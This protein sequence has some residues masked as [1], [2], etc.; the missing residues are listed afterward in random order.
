M[1]DAES[2]IGN[3]TNPSE[4][5]AGGSSDASTPPAAP[6]RSFLRELPV[7]VIIAFVLAVLIKTF[8]AQAFFIPSESMVPTLEVGD[9]ILVNKLAFRLREPQRG[10]IIVFAEQY[11]AAPRS[12][13]SRV[14]SVL[15]EG[16]GVTRPAETDF[17][18]R[19]IG[20]PGETVRLSKGVVTITDT[21]G[22]EITLDESYVTGEPDLEPFGPYTV[23]PG[24]YFVM[25]D[26]RP[27]SADSRTR[28][29]PI[30]RADIVGKAFVRIWPVSRFTLFHRPVYEAS[31]P[32]RP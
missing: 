32:A 2:P 3:S 19:V 29:G 6:R 27:N 11:D 5:S 4:I 14:R 26:N 25:G 31:Q 30:D 16:L 1:D 17:I 22:K 20:L 21:A 12:F 8:L 24:T 18:K 15:F 13:L 10:E 28:L 7:L 23:P 9:R